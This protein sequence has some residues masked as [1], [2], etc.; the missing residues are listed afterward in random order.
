VGIKFC[1]AA[2]S[3]IEWIASIRKTAAARYE[4]TKQVFP[5]IG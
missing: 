2:V 4:A 3:D 1:R 5:M